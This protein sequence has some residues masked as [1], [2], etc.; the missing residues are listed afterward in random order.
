MGALSSAPNGSATIGML[1]QMTSVHRTTVKRLLH[2]LIDEGYVRQS[3]SD[4]SYSLS[5]QVRQLSEGFRDDDWVTEV[6]SPAINELVKH[7]LWPSDL[8]TLSGAGMVIR[9]TSH[10]F[11]SL[12]FHRSM[13]LQRLPLLT[14]AA[15]R[16]YFC[17]CSEQER[18]QLI[19][20]IQSE[21]SPQSQL[22]KNATFL[23]QLVE[24]TQLQGYASNEGDWRQESDTAAIAIPIMHQKRVLSTLN[25]VFL[26]KVLTPKQAAEHYL[27]Y[28]K[29]TVNKIENTLKEKNI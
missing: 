1:S 5:Y 25:L 6:A 12:S 19:S 29:E 15:G 2:T 8:C 3:A 18:Q 22:A 26:K 21:S 9:E 24:K 16:A 28:L 10:R 11:S 13:V 20:I 17:F 14:T 4:N 7:T 27:C 23:N